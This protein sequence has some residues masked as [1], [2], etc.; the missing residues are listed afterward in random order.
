MIKNLWSLIHVHPRRKNCTEVL[1]CESYNCRGREEFVSG[2]SQTHGA[3]LHTIPLWQVDF[4]SRTFILRFIQGRWKLLVFSFT[5]G[6]KT[7]VGLFNRMLGFMYIFHLIYSVYM[8]NICVYPYS[9]LFKFRKPFSWC[10]HQTGVWPDT[11]SDSD[12]GLDLLLYR[13]RL[14]A[15]QCSKDILPFHGE[16]YAGVSQKERETM[17]KVYHQILLFFNSSSTG[18]KIRTN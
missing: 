11:A 7:F 13:K 10:W 8:Y 17:R 9:C 14:N 12:L 18:Q 2:V 4:T 1:W 5:G 16:W 6:K 3:P 15:R